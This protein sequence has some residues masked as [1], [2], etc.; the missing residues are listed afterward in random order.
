M[1]CINIYLLS[2]RKWLNY[3]TEHKNSMR[4][5]KQHSGKPKRVR[6]G[7]ITIEKLILNENGMSGLLQEKWLT[8]EVDY[9]RSM[10]L[11]I[12]VGIDTTLFIL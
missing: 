9:K 11:G 12:K 7:F 1:S 2:L 4:I 8:H 5:L 6:K 10:M 3:G